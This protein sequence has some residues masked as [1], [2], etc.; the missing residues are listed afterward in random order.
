MWFKS[1]G[2]ISHETSSVCQTKTREK[3]T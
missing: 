3:K 2:Y 1:A